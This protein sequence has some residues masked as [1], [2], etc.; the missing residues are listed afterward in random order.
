MYSDTEYLDM[1][2]VLHTTNDSGNVSLADIETIVSYQPVWSDVSW[3]T[4][5]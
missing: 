1:L 5:E 2:N 3:F 4:S